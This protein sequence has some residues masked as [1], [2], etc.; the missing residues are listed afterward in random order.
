MSVNEWQVGKGSTGRTD[1][2]KFNDHRG[3]SN[4]SC[5]EKREE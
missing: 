4:L 2:G 1:K 5:S 3:Y